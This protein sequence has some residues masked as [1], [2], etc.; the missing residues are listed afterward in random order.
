MVG[1]VQSDGADARA[2]RS[3]KNASRVK[4]VKV[5]MDEN[6]KTAVQLRV[7]SAPT[8]LLFRNGKVQATQGRHNV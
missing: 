2:I 1:P 7:R 6:Q 8:L 4:V 5:K 3:G